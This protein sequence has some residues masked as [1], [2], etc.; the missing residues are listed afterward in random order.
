[1]AHVSEKV[2][3]NMLL[4]RCGPDSE[5]IYDG[6][7][8]DEEHEYDLELIWSLFDKHCEPICNFRAA[9]WKFRSVSQAPNETLDTFYNQISKLA[10]QCQFDPLEE[11]LRLIDA[12]IYGTSI[13]K[14]QEKLLQTPKSLTLDQCLNICRHYKSLKLHLDTIKPKSIEY[15]QKCHNK[16]RKQGQGCG[17]GRGKFQQ[18]QQ[19]G[20]SESDDRKPGKWKCY[21]CGSESK[22]KISSCPGHKHVCNK[23]G[24]KG[25]FDQ[26][27]KKSSFNAANPQ[28]QQKPKSV[29][30]MQSNDLQNTGKLQ[31]NMDMVDMIRSLGLHEQRES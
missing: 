15:L 17:C 6:F 23:C 3:V 25:H 30:E 10:K 4:L 31:N 24:L 2:K 12:I 27:C 1:M 16:S 28:C 18:F 22:H 19:P 13:V 8:L 11:K 29:Q 20:K 26:V 21:W 14:A 5:D 7:E 9:R